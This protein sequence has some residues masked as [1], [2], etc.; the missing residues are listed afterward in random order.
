MDDQLLD[1]L[2]KNL[3]K[4]VKRRRLTDGEKR[5]LRNVTDEL[6]RHLDALQEKVAEVTQEKKPKHHHKSVKP[7]RRLGWRRND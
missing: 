2:A 1:L 4:N 5:R 7:R 6:Q 3:F